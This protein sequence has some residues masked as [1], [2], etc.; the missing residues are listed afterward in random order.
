MLTQALSRSGESALSQ[1]QRAAA[2]IAYLRSLVLAPP[3]Q[4]E[5][6]HAIFLDPH[7]NWLGDAPCG[8]GTMTTLAIRMR[9]LL[10]DA[11]R[12]DAAGI[13]LAHSHPS[14]HCRPSGCDIATTRRLAEIARALD[15]TLIDHLIFT[16]DAV[17]SMRAGG[18][19]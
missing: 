17:Y 6:G 10:G 18:L 19:L 9:A 8:I 4:Y 11:L 3:A 1:D 2:M 14:G 5:R 16:T 15:I 13:I 7:S 12:H